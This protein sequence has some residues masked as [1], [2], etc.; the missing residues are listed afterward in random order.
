MPR[1]ESGSSSRAPDGQDE[2][3][4]GL[5]VTILGS[6]TLLPDDEHRSAAHLVE[7]PGF[8][9]LWDCGSGTVHGM[10]RYGVRWRELS[11]L[12]ISHFHTDHFGDLPA[13]MWALKHGV[14][15][16]RDHALTILGPR[17][18]RRRLTLLA[19]AYGP[20]ILDPG[21]PVDVVEFEA[22]DDWADG[23]AG[24]RL[25][26]HPARH[27]P[28]ALAFRID[29]GALAVGYTGDTG[30]LPLLGPFFQG[31]DLLIAECA[32]ADDSGAEAHL[33]PTGV[34]SLLR[35]ADPQLTV[36]THLYPEVERAALPDLIRG[37]GY[38]GDVLVGHDGLSIRIRPGQTPLSAVDGSDRTPDRQ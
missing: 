15:E 20:F 26:A 38:T 4:A 23:D 31:V 29:A 3:A 28:E 36:L 10:E 32:L 13:L 5:Q 14:G 24:L 30:H 21:F 27:T 1:S 17:G 16:E 7:G 2:Y 11:H 18:L 9:L 37:L 19:E 25:R 8:G 22:E 34:A 12:A 33:T 35:D 6:G